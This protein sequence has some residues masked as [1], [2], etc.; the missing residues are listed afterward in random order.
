MAL[1]RYLKDNVIVWIVELIICGIFAYFNV[2]NGSTIS[3]NN[4]TKDFTSI[5]LTLFSAFIAIY[6]LISSS[7]A[8]L[9][10]EIAQK[11]S[12][13]KY[14]DLA[15]QNTNNIRFGI[16]EGSVVFVILA[17]CF[18]F[19]DIAGQRS[20]LCPWLLQLTELFCTVTLLLHFVDRPKMA[21]RQGFSTL[22]AL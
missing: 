4:L 9:C 7:V 3:I 13:P 11:A 12:E 1:L 8:K 22:P 18:Y 17:L 16:L 20:W 2:R 5:W 6:A 19:N 21:V 15:E 14:W 10:I